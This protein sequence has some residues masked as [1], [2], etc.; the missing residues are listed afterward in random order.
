M[1]LRAALICLALVPSPAW[2]EDPYY[3]HK[4]G[5][6][7]EGYAADVEYCAGLAVGARRPGRTFYF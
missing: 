7:R 2:A 1:K 4:A 5:I 6:T 3:F